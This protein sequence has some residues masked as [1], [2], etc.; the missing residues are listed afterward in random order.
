MQFY[1]VINVF[2]IKGIINFIFFIVIDS[3]FKWLP[4]YR[5]LF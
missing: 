4:E 5:E 2:V 3:L 1:Y